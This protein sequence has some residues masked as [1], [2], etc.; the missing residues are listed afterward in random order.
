MATTVVQM[1]GFTGDVERDTNP[2]TGR[3]FYHYRV[4]SATDRFRVDGAAA[5]I[6]EAVQSIET[7][8][9]YVLAHPQSR[10]R[11]KDGACGTAQRC[12]VAHF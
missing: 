7:L 10:Q 4:R 11:K 3:E 1:A 5:D 2:L 6:P 12:R 9:R 8:I